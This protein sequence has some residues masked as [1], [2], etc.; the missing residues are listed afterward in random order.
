MA[1]DPLGTI[2]FALIAYGIPALAIYAIYKR[3]K[4]KRAVKAETAE[5]PK[6]ERK[7]GWYARHLDRVRSED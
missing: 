1:A 6:R 4:A 5:K 7:L 3:V 2:V